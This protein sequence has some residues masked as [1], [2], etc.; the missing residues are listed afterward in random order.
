MERYADALEAYRHVLT[1]EPQDAEPYANF[2]EMSLTVNGG[3]VD[4]AAEAAFRAALARDRTEPRSRFY[5]GL[6]ASQQGDA[7][8][9]IAIWRDLTA[10]SPADAPWLEMVRTQMFQ[11][12]QASAIMPMQVAPRHPLDA[13]GTTNTTAPSPQL[14]PQPAAP[15]DI[16]TP[17]VSAIQGQ[18]SNENLAQIQAMVGSLAGRLEN[19]PDD[20]NG[21]LMLGR[22][23]TVLRNHQGAEGAFAKAM[24]LRPGDLGAKLGYITAA[25]NGAD[26]QGNTPLPPKVVD[27]AADVLKISADQPEALFVRGLRAAKA[28]DTAGAKRDWTAAKSKATGGLAAELDRRLKTLN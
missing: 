12:A 17:D 7:Q 2:G 4:E 13:P 18:F 28:G 6:A 22:S 26:L 5:L 15:G 16:T 14:A 24:E 1:L 3:R 10:D 19:N 20:Y 23:Y 21:W 25:L 11:V 9:A 8:T 27:V